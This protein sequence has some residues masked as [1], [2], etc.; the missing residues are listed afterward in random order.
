[1]NQ[2]YDKEAYKTKKKAELD[3]IFRM[4]ND[5]TEGLI[6]DADKFKAYLDVQARLDR[7]SVSNAILVAKQ[8][9]W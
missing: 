9:P 7:Y 4:L 5:A 8:L 3:E 2:E 6:S 1:M